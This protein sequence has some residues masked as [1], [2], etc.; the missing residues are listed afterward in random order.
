M[1]QT[2]TTP[3][4]KVLLW[5]VATVIVGCHLSCEVVVNDVA[6][7]SAACSGRDAWLLKV[8]DGASGTD[9]DFTYCTLS[10]TII[11]VSP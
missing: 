4:F 8:S 6:L 3:V 2:G 5:H 10:I 1:V 7:K 11:G 9:A